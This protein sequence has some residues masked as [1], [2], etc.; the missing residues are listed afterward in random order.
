L[1]VATEKLQIGPSLIDAVSFAELTARV[2]GTA[3]RL[4]RSAHADLPLSFGEAWSVLGYW[5]FAERD[6]DVAVVEVGAGGR[7]DATN[8]VNPVVSVITSVGLDHVVTLGPEIADIAWHKA[9]I[10][11]PGATAVVGDLPQAALSVIA[12]TANAASVDLIRASSVARSRT[13]PPPEERR[14]QERNAEMA[15]AVANVLVQRGFSISDAAIADGIRSARLPGRLERMPGTDD[16]AIWI[17]GA[18]NEDKITAVTQQAVSRFGGSVLP[19]IVVGML[20]SKDSAGVIARLRTAASTI[21]TTEP[22]VIGKRSRAAD[23]LAGAIAASGFAG[24][25]HVHPDPDAAVR[26]AEVLAKREGAAVLVTGSRYLVGQVR[27]RWFPDRDVVL[28]RTPWPSATEESRLGPPR[29]FGGLVCDKADG[30]RD[31]TTDHQVSAR[32]DELVVR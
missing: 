19:V 21:I 16:P 15:T 27:R 30:E 20:S 3:T 7:F 24:P 26:L 17:D 12:A 10:I 5:W 29:P 18:H 25:V 1:Q 22:S 2:L 11:K 13:H 9:G 23:A 32:A 6:V 28:Q 8:V 14:F 4:A 31:E